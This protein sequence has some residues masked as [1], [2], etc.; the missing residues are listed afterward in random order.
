MEHNIIDLAGQHGQ[1]RPLPPLKSIRKYCLSCATRPKDVRECSSNEC[2][3]FRY[4]MGKNP[5]RAGIAPGKSNPRSIPDGLLPN[6]TR[7]FERN[8]TKD[9]SSMAENESL[10]PGPANNE[11]RLVRMEAIGKIQMTGRRIVIELTQG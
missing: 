4:R 3:L 2:A 5:S 9:G 6:S 11:I 7:F 8:R 10:N 1:D